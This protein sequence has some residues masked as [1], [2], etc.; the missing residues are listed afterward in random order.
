MAQ[1]LQRT[2]TAAQLRQQEEAIQ[3]RI[4]HL[5]AERKLIRAQYEQQLRA[6]L[7]RNLVRYVMD[8]ARVSMMVAEESLIAA[9]NNVELAI[10]LAVSHGAARAA[11]Q[12]TAAAQPQPTQ[13]RR[14]VLGSGTT[15][16]CAPPQT[17]P[18]RPLDGTRCHMAGPAP[19]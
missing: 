7:P 18:P 11:Q 4:T 15:T 14:P 10:E 6:E 2:Y 1:F 12:Q 17:F 19:F 3:Q 9:A 8:G 5:E 16:V 13:P